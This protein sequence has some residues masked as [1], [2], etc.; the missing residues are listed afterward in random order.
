MTDELARQIQKQIR[1][2][3]RHVL[4]TLH[5]HDLDDVSQEL[6]GRLISRGLDWSQDQSRWMFK[7]ASN[8]RSRR[9][10]QMRRRCAKLPI[11]QWPE[12]ERILE[13]VKDGTGDGATAWETRDDIKAAIRTLPNATRAT[14]TEYYL[15]GRDSSEIAKTHGI[16]VEAVHARLHYARHLLR[17]LLHDY[18]CEHGLI[19]QTGGHH[20]Q[21]SDVQRVA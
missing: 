18:G 4:H 21:G 17:E 5:W 3:A 19:D 16:S 11:E 1:G 10:K 6:F 7:E 2:I 12:G 20:D 13:N 15:E 14:V 9:S 8:L